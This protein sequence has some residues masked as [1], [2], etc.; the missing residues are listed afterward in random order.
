MAGGVARRGVLRGMSLRARLILLAGAC[1]LPSAAL[2]AI[3]QVQ[4]RQAREA[5]VRREI[6]QLAQSAAAEIDA[7][8][9]GARQLLTALEQAPPIRE[10]NAA[11]CSS[12]LVR[13][14]QEYPSYASITA[15]DLGGRS[16]CSSSPGRAGFDG[17]NY[18]FRAALDGRRFV[19]GNF[20][21]SSV[22]D[23]SVLS[24]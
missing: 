13:L 12:L 23:A 21:A 11:L 22:A 5:D 17:D 16:F 3:N 15:D 20:A 19:V 24:L 18:A 10:H 14:K 8:T 2:L 4:L 7:V 9:G 6:A 1:M